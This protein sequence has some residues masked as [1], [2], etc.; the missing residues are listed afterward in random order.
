MTKRSH[1]LS[2]SNLSLLPLSQL[3][4]LLLVKLQKP[5][6][7]STPEWYH[8]YLQIQHPASFWHAVKQVLGCTPAWPTGF[9][10]HLNTSSHLSTIHLTQTSQTAIFYS[11]LT[12]TIPS[13]Q[14][15]F[16]IYRTKPQSPCWSKLRV[17]LHSYISK[18]HARLIDDSVLILPTVWLKQLAL[19]LRIVWTTLNCDKTQSCVSPGFRC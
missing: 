8:V 13:T 19:K 12:I 15:T 17:H 5:E 18:P 4:A 2:L 3:M 9:K 7:H 10:I 1:L 11:H 6:S 16:L 14:N